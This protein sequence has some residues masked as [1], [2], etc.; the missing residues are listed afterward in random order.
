[1]RQNFK[2][3]IYLDELAEICSE[4]SRAAGFR[5]AVRFFNDT[6]QLRKF[7]PGE[8][9]RQFHYLLSLVTI[10]STDFFSCV[11]DCIADMA[12]FTVLAKFENYYNTKIAELGE[13]FIPRKF[14]AMQ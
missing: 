1:M 11:K 13:N 12:T 4:I 8:S 3:G 5:G 7:S 9:F 10:L 2:G 6:I 14:S